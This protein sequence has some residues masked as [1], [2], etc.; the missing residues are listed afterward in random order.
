MLE[1]IKGKFDEINGE[2]QRKREERERIAKE[3]A[4]EKARI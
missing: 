3:R 4:E 1:K 2:S